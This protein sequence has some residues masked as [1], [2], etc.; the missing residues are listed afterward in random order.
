MG[1]E[2]LEHVR[3][4]LRHFVRVGGYEGTQSED[5]GMPSQDGIRFRTAEKKIKNII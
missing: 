1:T 4:K 2:M 5:T 3:H